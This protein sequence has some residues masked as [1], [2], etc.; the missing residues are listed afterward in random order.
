MP[1]VLSGR[2]LADDEVKR[3]TFAGISIPDMGAVWYYDGDP[4]IASLMAGSLADVV[5]PDQFYSDAV[6]VVPTPAP[7]P[8]LIDPAPLPIAIPQPVDVPIVLADVIVGDVA[9]ASAFGPGTTPLDVLDPLF[10]FHDQGT[11]AGG[12][13]TPMA[14]IE[15]EILQQSPEAQVVLAGGGG[16]LAIRTAAD[17]IRRIPGIT[18]LWADDVIR[19]AG[20]GGGPMTLAE[21]WASLTPATQAGLAALGLGLG[22]IAI[23]ELIIDIPGFGLPGDGVSGQFA[24]GNNVIVGTWVANGVKFYRL[25]DGRLAVQNK[26]GRWKVWRPKKP[27]VLYAGGASNLKTMLRAD[28]ALDKQAKRIKKMLNR[29]APSRRSPKTQT[30]AHPSGGVSVVNVD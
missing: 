19:V 23:N 12:S 29:R 27:I 26:R 25:L 10:L 22:T 11:T 8:L 15:Q 17:L 20:S 9:S 3:L 28:A 14:S 18:Q 16:A 21:T 13:I 1:Y 2:I 4:V 24:V 7:A 30:H 5:T 6:G